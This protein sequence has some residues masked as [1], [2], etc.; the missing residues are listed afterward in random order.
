M[1]QK[2]EN[3]GSSSDGEEGN[4]WWNGTVEIC[5]TRYNVKG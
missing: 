5:C 2:R 4:G 3:T 1:D